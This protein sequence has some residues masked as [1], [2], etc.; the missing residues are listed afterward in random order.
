MNILEQIISANS[1]PNPAS[2]DAY[3]GQLDAMANPDPTKQ[4]I[5]AIA[6]AMASFGG[7]M[8]QPQGGVSHWTT[9]M[10][11]AFGAANQSLD[12]TA[13]TQ[14]KQK[15]EAAKGMYDLD[16]GM[17]KDKMA[18]LIQ[19][20]GAQHS[21]NRDSR[22]A[23]TAGLAQDRFTHTKGMNEQ[24][25]GLNKD[26]F[27]HTK[28]MDEQRLKSGAYGARK[29]PSQ[30]QIAM[31]I[32]KMANRRFPPL[33]DGDYPSQDEVAKRQSDRNTY[34]KRLQEQFGRRAASQNQSVSGKF[35]ETNPAKPATQEAFEALPS[36]TVFL[37]PKDG[38]MYRKP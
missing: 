24:R 1:D 30:T 21:S 19:L 31:D 6:N 12:K 10:G 27:A 20:L 3:R 34:V 22:G 7:G 14:E 5:N 11:N 8:G 37:N 16:K 36:G 35:S 28:N 17:Q 23:A 32:E 29:P 33:K 18:R 25:F 4:K 15:F 13:Q 2:M 9:R 38:Q 26:K